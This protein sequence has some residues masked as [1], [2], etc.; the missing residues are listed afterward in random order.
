[1]T[2]A[3]KETA[4]RLGFHQMTPREMAEMTCVMLA[5]CPQYKFEEL[6]KAELPALFYVKSNSSYSQAETLVVHSVTA[7]AGQA[8]V[9]RWP[10]PAQFKIYKSNYK[11]EIF[12]A[13]TPDLQNLLGVTHEQIV[14]AAVEAKLQIPVQVRILYPQLFVEIPASIKAERVRKELSPDFVRFDEQNGIH[15]TPETLVKAIEY[16]HSRIVIMSEEKTL[17]MSKQD[18]QE[19]LETEADYDEYIKKH[20]DNITFYRWL[21]PLVQPGAVFGTEK[22]LSGEPAF[23]K[24]KAPRNFVVK[25][26]KW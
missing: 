14:T 19:A 10:N 22:K 5:A 18:L 15:T 25:N 9:S 4:F 26:R 16:E 20:R 23:D 7:K 3:Q 12:Y 13:L 17:R 1:M 21:E 11:Y 2:E 8:T 24:D 6:K